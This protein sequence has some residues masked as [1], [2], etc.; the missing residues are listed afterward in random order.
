MTDRPRPRHSRSDLVEALR[1]VFR[2]R[3][4]DGAS[5]SDL[6]AATGL[7]RATLYHHFPNGKAD[8]AAAAL[9][10]VETRLEAEMLAPLRGPGTP[11]ERLDGMVR[12]LDA[13]YRGGDLGCL[14]G[15]LSRGAAEHG[16]GE[17]VAAAFAAWTDT[18]CDLARASGLS[19]ERARANAV[20]VVAALQGALVLAAATRSSEPFDLALA[21]LPELLFAPEP[22][23]GRDGPADFDTRGRSV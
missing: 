15:A 4:W 5:L 16:L 12:T 19:E 3:G 14:L 9:G 17:R 10:D 18:L 8:M 11:A 20:A 22:R 7:N 23:G 21:R 1:D 13:Y 2:A 6:A